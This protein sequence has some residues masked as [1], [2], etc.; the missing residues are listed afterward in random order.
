MEATS[1]R[2]ELLTVQE[3]ARLKNVHPKAIYYGLAEGKLTRHEQYG[4]ILLDAAEVA[5]YQPRAGGLRGKLGQAPVDQPRPLSATAALFASW[6]AEDTTDDP[7]ELAR[8]QRDGDELLAA[9]N[10]SPL[11]LRWVELPD[12]PDGDAA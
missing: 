3:A 4:R 8:R 10:E 2:K 6:E 11:S 12:L 7:E 1:R 5:A 9:L